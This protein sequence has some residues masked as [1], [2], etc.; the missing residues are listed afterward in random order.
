MQTA[1]PLLAPVLALAA[2]V[3]GRSGARVLAAG[4]IGFLLPGLLL[5][6]TASF[7]ARLTATGPSPPHDTSYVGGNSAGTS[8]VIGLILAALAAVQ[9]FKERSGRE[10][11]AVTLP[12]ALLYIL[13]VAVSFALPLVSSTGAGS[14]GDAARTFARLSVLSSAAGLLTILSAVG[15]MAVILVVPLNR[16]IVERGRR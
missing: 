8:I 7:L 15:L 11:R 6:G 9:W 5:G 13:S 4:A 3:T 14:V 16:L 2:A 10:D 12:L 1:I